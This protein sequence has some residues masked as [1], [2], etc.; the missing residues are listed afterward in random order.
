MQT[1]NRRDVLRA[2]GRLPVLAGL[3]ALAAA[4]GGGG[5]MGTGYGG[6]GGGGGGGSTSTLTCSTTPMQSYTIAG[7]H[8]HTACIDQAVLTA[9]ATSNDIALTLGSGHT[10]TVTLTQAQVDSIRNGT[11]TVAMTSSVTSGHS[12]VVTYTP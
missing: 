4:C 10:H 6:S 9:P 1:W 8:G 3:S 7:N 2:L 12:H 11:A 5:G